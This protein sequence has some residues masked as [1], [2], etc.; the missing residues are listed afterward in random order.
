MAISV[1]IQW[2]L[3]LAAERFPVGAARVKGAARWRVDR[4]GHISFEHDA[5]FLARGVGHRH[6]GQQRACVRMFGVAVNRL[7]IGDLDDLA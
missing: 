6:S 1:K 3:G 2:R 5:F 7:G 4:T